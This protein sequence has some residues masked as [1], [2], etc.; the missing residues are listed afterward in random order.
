MPS[1]FTTVL[2]RRVSPKFFVNGMKNVGMHLSDGRSLHGF[3]SLNCY[4]NS[5]HPLCAGSKPRTFS[6][7]NISSSGLSRL[8]HPQRSLAWPSARL[9]PNTR[10]RTI[11]VVVFAVSSALPRTRRISIISFKTNRRQPQNKAH[12]SKP[13]ILHPLRWL[14]RQL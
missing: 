14:L 3:S 8:A 11:R 2:H 13:Q 5:L 7:S 10:P 9:T 1:S 4:H 6:L 12:L